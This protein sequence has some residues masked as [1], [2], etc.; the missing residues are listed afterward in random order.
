MA[1][2]L[3]CERLEFVGD[4]GRSLRAIVR[5]RSQHVGDQVVEIGM[6]FGSQRTDRRRDSRD[7]AHQFL[8]DGVAGE[9]HVTGQHL[10]Q[11]TAETEDVGADIGVRRAHRLF[12]RDV[13]GSPQHCSGLSHRIQRERF[14]GDVRQAEVEDA[15]VAKSGFGETKMF[16]G[17]MSRWTSPCS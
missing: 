15:G 16:D 11:R 2:N 10:E 9:R 17:L 1:A 12:G 14:R 3:E 6:R 7:A 13:I 8:H 4:L 5:I